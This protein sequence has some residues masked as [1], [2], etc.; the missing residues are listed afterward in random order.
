MVGCRFAACL[1]I[2]GWLACG[3]ELGA[4]DYVRD[5][6]ADAVKAGKSPVAHWGDKDDTYASWSSHSNRLIP[7]YSYGT[8]NAA[9]GISQ[10]NYK[11]ALNPYHSET[12]LKRLY[13]RIP[14]NTLNPEAEY[15]DQTNLFDIQ[16]AALKAGKKHIFLVVFDGMDWQTTQ[17]A[18]IYLKQ[19]V[20]YN[21]GRGDAL[22]FQ[23]YNAG[24]T[25]EFGYMVTSPHNEGTEVD[26]DAQT[27]KNPGGAIFG[28]YDP[29][30]GGRFPWGI[31]PE[32]PYL[33]TAPKTDT[34][35]QAYTDSSSSATS[36]TAGI[37]TYNNAVNV[38]ANGA[39]VATIAHL[40][41]A[42]GYSVGAITTVPICHA[43]PAAAYAHNVHRDDYQDLTRDLI[44]LPSIVHPEQ[45]LSGLDVLIG[46]GWGVEIPK[47]SG[48]GK[49][50][51]V[52]NQYLT[53]ADKAKV[54]VDNGGKYV[55]AERTAGVAGPDTLE[56]A[57]ER[58]IHEKKRLLGYYGVATTGHLPFATADGDFKPSPGRTGKS[59]QYTEADLTENVTL[60]EMTQAA[61]QVLSKNP[62]GFWLMVEAGDVD[63]ANH[64][65]NL[66]NS[67]GAV[68]SGDN[69][70]K[71]ITDW[72]E[73]SSNW[74]ESVVIVTADHGHYLFLDHPEQLIDPQAKVSDAGT[75]N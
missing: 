36:M 61:I 33:I 35:K 67:I 8:K 30:R 22:H 44:G 41:Q 53:D 47:S 64:D 9:A 40:A 28:G 42:E 7:V 66:D 54:N 5:L 63:W 24:G 4:N 51:V 20:S 38:D 18:A 3:I 68:I 65:N 74:N 31:A 21:E 15:F 11:G 16:Q 2:A 43:T 46:A 10:S 58:A 32:I 19:K 25:A 69:A 60:K 39:P 50:F 13:G 48:Q 29:N 71:A 45:P 70:V 14:E 56:K 55:V 75:G 62:K 49:N 57:V 34:T 52:G 26:V 73:K 27:V 72:V 23:K 12:A 17:A 6:Q 59:E 37:K 1:G